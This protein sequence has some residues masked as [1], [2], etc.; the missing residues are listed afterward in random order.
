MGLLFSAAPC[1]YNAIQHIGLEDR[2][3]LR[4]VQQGAPD[5][6]DDPGRDLLLGGETETVGT[7]LHIHVA[8]DTAIF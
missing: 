5:L 1:I 4:H 3:G 7:I 8:R 2:L 6:T